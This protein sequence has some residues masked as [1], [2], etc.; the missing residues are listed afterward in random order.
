MYVHFYIFFHGLAE[1]EK[2]ED[3]H[4]KKMFKYP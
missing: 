3:M 4:L 1:P 2:M